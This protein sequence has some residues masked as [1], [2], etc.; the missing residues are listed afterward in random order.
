[1]EARPEP[2][3]SRELGRE[4]SGPGAE[5]GKIYLTQRLQQLLVRAEDEAK[6]L[7]DEYVSVEHL[8][9]AMIDEGSAAP[10]G[11]VLK[12]HGLTRDKLLAALTAVRGNQ[13]VTSAMPEAAYEA[14]EKYGTDLVAMA[15]R[16]KL[17]P[18]IGRDEEIRRVVR[19]R[20]HQEQPG[21]DRRARRRQ[22]RHRRG[23]GAAHRAATPS[24]QDRAFFSLDMGSSPAPYGGSSRSA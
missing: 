11:R 15:R 5:A 19:I 16:N 14:L 24:G 4:A 18:V 17:D 8:A 1:M 3:P 12:N 9:L 6:R 2:A 21:A 10:A 13:R 23:T 22:D 7:K 20:R